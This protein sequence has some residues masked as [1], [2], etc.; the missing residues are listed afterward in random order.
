MK[1]Y[2]IFKGM[3]YSTHLLRPLLFPKSM[4]F[5]FILNDKS[6]YRPNKYRDE[7]SVKQ[8]KFQVNKI[9]GMT[10]DFFG[11]NSV[12]L[13]YR[14]NWEKDT[15]E[16]LPYY[17]VNGKRMWF[18]EQ[19]MEIDKGFKYTCKISVSS[20]NGRS[21]VWIK[22]FRKDTPKRLMIS[23]IRW[24]ETGKTFIGFRQY[25]YFGGSGTGSKAPNNVQILIDFK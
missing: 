22:V 6:A 10:L 25:P 18:E 15:F 23:D 7:A 21:S 11:K 14:Y 1:K 16:V 3:H 13:G 8:L 24:F 12:R 9:G 4:E 17:H 2:I 19:A 5:D 20:Y